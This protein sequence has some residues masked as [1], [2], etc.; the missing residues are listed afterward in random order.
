M[1]AALTRMG[2]VDRLDY[3]LSRGHCVAKAAH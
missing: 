2:L 3:L 1:L